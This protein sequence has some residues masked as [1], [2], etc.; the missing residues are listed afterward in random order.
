[1]SEE[2]DRLVKEHR[3][4]FFTIARNHYLSSPEAEDVVQETFYKAWRGFATFKKDIPF[5]NWAM[6]I[7]M[8]EIR[9]VYRQKKRKP[10][11]YLED[12]IREPL[13]TDPCTQIVNANGP[14]QAKL[15]DVPKKYREAFQLFADGRSYEDIGKRLNIP[16]GTVK[17]RLCRARHWLR[18]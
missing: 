13:M 5:Q 1:M 12:Q 8:N 14:Y 11:V 16:V 7:L 15:R 18:A 17:S 4:Y 2:F 6:R 9:E 3:G 10:F